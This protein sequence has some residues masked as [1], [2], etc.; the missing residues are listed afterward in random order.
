MKTRIV[1]QQGNGIQVVAPYGDHAPGDMMLK[2]A[3]AQLFGG[4]S[5]TATVKDRSK[6][7]SSVGAVVD[8][9]TH[10]PMGA[11][12]LK[13]HL[14]GPGLELSVLGKILPALRVNPTPEMMIEPQHIPW[15]HEP[16]SLKPWQMD[17][18][19]WICG[20]LWEGSNVMTQ[21]RLRG[22]LHEAGDDRIA[23]EPVVDTL[24]SSLN[25]KGS[26]TLHVITAAL[27][28][29]SHIVS[30]E[31]VVDIDRGVSDVINAAERALFVFDVNTVAQAFAKQGKRISESKNCTGESSCNVH[32]DVLLLGAADF[33][34]QG[35]EHLQDGEWGRASECF[36][37]AIDMA[38]RSVT[39]FDDLFIPAVFKGYAQMKLA[40]IKRCDQA[41]A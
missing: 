33:I 38:Q 21:A 18:Y 14:R 24:R 40:A 2:Y 32:S 22:I 36:S 17:M 26:I 23:L 8:V 39:E 15:F 9:Y 41:T 6:M 13:L 27:L 12:Q 20:L 29:F 1:M 7:S 34:E 3:G 28:N 5:I 19:M 31:D 25:F 4:Q 11:G 16:T 35:D 37:R 30:P 10:E